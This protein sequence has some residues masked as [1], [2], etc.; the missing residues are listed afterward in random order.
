MSVTRNHEIMEELKRMKAFYQENG[1]GNREMAYERALQSVA[2]CRRRITSGKDAM[3][4]KWIGKGIGW[5]IDQI[6]GTETVEEEEPK[7]ATNSRK[8][9]I[10]KVSKDEEPIKL[11]AQFV[12]DGGRPHRTQRNARRNGNV[13]PAQGF[14]RYRA[15]K[16]LAFVQDIARQ[17]N[18][19]SHVALAGEYRR[20]HSS[21]KRVC[22]LLTD[23]TFPSDTRKSRSTLRQV[24]STLRKHRMIQRVNVDASGVSASADAIFKGCHVTLSFLCVPAVSWPTMLLKMTGPS[25]FWKKLQQAAHKRGFTLRSSGIIDRKGRAVSLHSEKDVF[26]VLGINYIS[27]SDRENF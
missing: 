19:K 2:R 16:L 13:R 1:D 4:L 27:V 23:K 17:T 26:S 22:F 15:A 21:L 20:G 25:T 5:R 24:L 10:A 12:E 6:L 9:K 14:A 8:R 18:A 7:K 11:K 3:R